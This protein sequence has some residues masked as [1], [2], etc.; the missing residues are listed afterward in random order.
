VETVLLT[1]VFDLLHPGHV[2]LLAE[3]KATWPQSRLIVGINGDRRTNELKPLVLF[4]AD[5]R[6][7]ILKSI[8]FVDQVVIFEEDTPRELILRL[9]PDVFVKGP[10]WKGKRIA[11]MDACEQV[12][13][14]VAFLGEKSHQS[15]ELKRRLDAGS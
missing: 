7:T 6:A 15:S 12:G 1:G 10:D 8:R 2:L 13:C 5:E 11:E 14:T 3:A 9:K 4:S